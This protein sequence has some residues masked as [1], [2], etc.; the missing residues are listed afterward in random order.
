MP[1]LPEAR[2]HWGL[3]AL[4]YAAGLL[5]ALQYAKIPH[6]LPGLLR[7]TAMGSLQ[8]AVALSVIGAAGLVAGTL[9]GALA[10]TVGLR[11]TLL[12]GMGV[13]VVGAL[14]PLAS[15]SYALLLLARLVESVAHMAMV[16]AV[17]TLIL[18][19]CAARDRSKAMALWSCFF[20][21]TFIA[22]AALAPG[23]LALAGWQGFAV[24]HALLLLVVAGAL[25]LQ[26]PSAIAA[27]SGIAPAAAPP[28]M[29]SLLHAQ[30]RLLL[31]T[32]LRSIP[33]TFFGYTL[34]F[35]ALLSVLPALITASPE[36][37]F[38][39]AVALP[40]AS[41]AGAVIAMLALRCAVAGYKLVRMSALG[42]VLAGASL[43]F[44][45]ATG[46]VS[47]SVVLVAF[48]LLGS[49]PAGIISTLPALFPADHPD[50]ALVN[51]GLVQ[52]GNLGNFVG[53]PIL[54]SLLVR[55]GWPGLGLY[56][57]AGALVVLL[58]M[59]F[60]QRLCLAAGQTKQG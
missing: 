23:V 40:C 43:V 41:L 22:T 59:L 25:S 50:I 10:Q 36:A 57:L 42:L 45:P 24:L 27:D 19:Y 6:M 38:Q 32:R 33:A 21:V 15:G 39:M 49:L 31:N 47:Q 46:P 4:L 29:R 48:V 1:P 5:A 13:G 35:V 26:L 44:L 30:R 58:G 7:Q 3:I 11:H 34:L 18:Q 9:A 60:L 14:M 56:M 20:T 54:A 55:F 2:T 17:P 12:V 16:V 53:S 37:A 51:G 52:F 28:S 8:Q